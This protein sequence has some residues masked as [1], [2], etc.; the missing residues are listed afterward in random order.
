MAD[1]TLSR[2]INL[3]EYRSFKWPVKIRIEADKSLW[4]SRRSSL[5]AAHISANPNPECLVRTVEFSRPRPCR[6]TLGSWPT[7]DWANVVHDI[8]HSGAETGDSKGEHLF[9]QKADPA[10]AP[11]PFSRRAR[12]LLCDDQKLVRRRVRT[13]LKEFPAVEVIGEAADGVSAVSLALELKPDLI[14][15]DV[16]MPELDGI[17][18]TRQI[19]LHEPL[20][21]VLAYSADS[22]E[23]VI[24]E[25]FAAGARGFLSKVAEP[26]NL[27]IGIT[28]VLAGER[29][30]SVPGNN[31][32]IPP[33]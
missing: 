5:F 15:M 32:P 26:E 2:K 22:S 11:L 25:M 8:Q 10:S 12:L 23:D 29:F 27:I 9:G 16:T 1:R 18:A 33:G 3:R 4:R 20:I 14:L 31:G 17:E 28:K 13:L 24:R 7:S 19:V 6:R 21:R 30:L